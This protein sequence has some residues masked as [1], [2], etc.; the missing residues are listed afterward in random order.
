MHTGDDDVELGEQV[1]V[2]VEGPVVE[3]VDLD[4]GEDAEG[5]ELLVE[6]GDDVEL[7]ARDARP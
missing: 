4:A 5:R 3:D 7:L 1:V 2:L 6:A